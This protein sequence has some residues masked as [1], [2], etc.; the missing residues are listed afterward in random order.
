MIETITTESGK[1]HL[2]R[3]LEDSLSLSEEFQWF[4]ILKDGT[5]PPPSISVR[6]VCDVQFLYCGFVFFLHLGL[7]CTC[8][9]WIYLVKNLVPS[10]SFSQD[11]FFSFWNGSGRIQYAC[12][13]VVLISLPSR[14]HALVLKRLVLSWSVIADKVAGVYSKG[15]FAP[16]S[17][18]SLSGLTYVQSL[19]FW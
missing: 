9:F 16:Y 1:G 11:W 17:H 14:T 2:P 3:N 12:A 6:H 13:W 15:F 7:W 4:K 5:P 8:N 18:F 10:N 19:V